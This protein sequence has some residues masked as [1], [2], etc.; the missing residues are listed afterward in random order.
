M[1]DTMST[2]SEKPR[3]I[4]IK[5]PLDLPTEDGELSRVRQTIIAILTQTDGLVV[6]PALGYLFDFIDD[7]W[8]VTHVGTGLRLPLT[9]PGEAQ[10]TAFAN[11]AGELA[12]WSV[13]HPSLPLDVRRQVVLLG[14]EHGGIP[15]QKVRE[16]L[17][18]LEAEE[19]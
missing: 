17:A 19:A 5:V 12:D 10:A 8:H 14:K 11:A 7:A 2:T 3:T 1:T 15:N 13:N 9:F 18:R 16:Q 6:F 4:S